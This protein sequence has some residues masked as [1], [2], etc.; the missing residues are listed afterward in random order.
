[1]G[2]IFLLHVFCV[3]FI[4]ESKY[5]VRIF[6]WRIAV[7]H[8]VKS[9]TSESHI[10][11]PRSESIMVLRTGARGLCSFW[12]VESLSR[13]NTTLQ[14]KSIKK[15]SD[16]YSQIKYRFK[17]GKKIL[18]ILAPPVF[19]TTKNI[20]IALGRSVS[21]SL[22]KMLQVIIPWLWFIHHLPKSL[23]LPCEGHVVTGW[24]EETWSL[25]MD[26]E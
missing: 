6:A 13:V 8:V 20:T 5:R 11:L 16:T 23:N 15:F 26:L 21:S 14:Y 18:K 2:F 1:M 3:H 4:F 22:P 12:L 17:L 10:P 19:W 25:G 24:N 9:V 7:H